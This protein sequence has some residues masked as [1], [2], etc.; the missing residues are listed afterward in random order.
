MLTAKGVKPIAVSQQAFEF[1]WVF[2]A[3]SPID[4]T[5]ANIADGTYAATVSD[6][7]YDKPTNLR[8]NA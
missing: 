7:P 8:H 6:M 4:G 2:G 1:T 5:T 3:F